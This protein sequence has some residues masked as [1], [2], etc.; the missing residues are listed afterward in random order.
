MHQLMPSNAA[1]A[2]SD[3]CMW[4]L[5]LTVEQECLVCGSVLHVPGMT[6]CI[7]ALYN[8]ACKLCKALVIDGLPHA[9]RAH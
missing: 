3:G 7:V 1:D 4:K 2:K 9:A 8:C 6:Y 5:W